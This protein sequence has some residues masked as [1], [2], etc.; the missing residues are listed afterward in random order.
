MD[1]GYRGRMRLALVGT[2]LV[3]ACAALTGC[4]GS[5]EAG[6]GLPTLSSADA[7]HALGGTHPATLHGKLR[8]DSNGFF[9]WA[10]TSGTPEDGAWI[11]WPD[12]AAQDAA[13]VVVDSSQRLRDGDA[14]TAVGA[15]AAFDDLPEAAD[16]VSYFGSFGRF[17]GAPGRGI[18]VL[19]RVGRSD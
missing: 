18:L 9:L 6:F 19:T 15:V 3:L 16:H 11:V 2:V 5:S 14:V 8:T 7:A 4:A 1:A 12:S 13:G 17:C 10:G